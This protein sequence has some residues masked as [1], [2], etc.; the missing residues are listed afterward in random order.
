MTYKHL[1]IE[2]LT[3]REL[4]KQL[5]SQDFLNFGARQIAY[6]RKVRVDGQQAYA[7]H[8]ADGTPLSVV[9]TL[10]SAMAVVRYSELEPASVH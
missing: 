8:D 10:D 4:L 1:N 7:V 9:D 3:P 6:I 5:S 2:D